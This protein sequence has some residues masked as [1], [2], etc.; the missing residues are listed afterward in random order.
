[1]DL[2]MN[3]DKWKKLRIR[4]IEIQNN[5]DDMKHDPIPYHAGQY[6]LIDIILYE[7][8][9]SNKLILCPI[10]KEINDE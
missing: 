4:L 6:D 1:M 2:T 10:C 3:E 8:F 9:D 7:F 5:I